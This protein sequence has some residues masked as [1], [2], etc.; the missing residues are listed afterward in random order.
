[1]SRAERMLSYEILGLITSR[2]FPGASSDEE[3]EEEQTAAS[4]QSPTKLDG[5]SRR[6]RRLDK[7][8]QN[9]D[10]AWCWREDC[11]GG[12]YPFDMHYLTRA[13]SPINMLLFLKQNRLSKVN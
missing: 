10:G 3:D 12:S 6:S 2:A 5:L 9:S 8:L 4:P 7:G 1:M 13:L 11:F